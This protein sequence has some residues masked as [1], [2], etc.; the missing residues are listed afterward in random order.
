MFE[1]FDEFYCKAK[2]DGNYNDILLLADN[3]FDKHPENDALFHRYINVL[4]DYYEVCENK[5]FVLQ[6]MQEVVSIYSEK[7]NLN[8]EILTDIRKIEE[9]VNLK[10]NEFIEKKNYEKKEFLTKIII[11]NDDVLDKIVAQV[12]KLNTVI[13]EKEFN[14]LVQEIKNLDETLKA[15]YFVERQKTKYD[16]LTKTTTEIIDKKIKYFEHLKK[17]DY[18]KEAINSYDK[19]YKIFKEGTG[20]YSD[21]LIKELFMYDPE[22]LFNETIVYYNHVYNYILSKLKDDDK[23]AITKLAIICEKK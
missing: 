3:L 18:N 22:K 1:L 6:R 8:K 12:E 5:E 19:V 15:D 14:T 20:S 17:V 4:F 23:F 21:G 2:N 16:K 13:N 7:V 9:K 10:H 11:Q